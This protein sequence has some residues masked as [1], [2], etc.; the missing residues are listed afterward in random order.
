MDSLKPSIIEYLGKVENG[1][2]VLIGIVYEE[3]YYESTFFY[4]DTD[5]VVTISEDL[6]QKIG[7]I[8]EHLEYPELIK[9]LI[10]NVIPHNELFERTDEVDFSRWVNGIIETQG[11]EAEDIDES[12]IKKEDE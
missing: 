4:T 12:E 8:K 2:L 10:K 9:F 1:I 11:D 7:D 5:M 3:T 6:E